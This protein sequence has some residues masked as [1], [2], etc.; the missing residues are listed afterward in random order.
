MLRFKGML[1]IFTTLTFFLKILSTCTIAILVS[2]GRKLKAVLIKTDTHSPS[3][4][5]M[6]ALL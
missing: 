1:R 3:S 4:N 6:R 5:L 2:R